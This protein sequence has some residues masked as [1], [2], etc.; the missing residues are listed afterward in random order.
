MTTTL[1]I[2][3]Y[4]IKV[5]GV[6]NSYNILLRLYSENIL[7]S[8]IIVYQV[9][10]T[11]G[12]SNELLIITIFTVA[13]SYVSHQLVITTNKRFC[14]YFGWDSKPD[15]KLFNVWC[16]SFKISYIIHSYYLHSPNMNIYI[17][18]WY[19]SMD[20][21]EKWTTYKKN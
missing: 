10:L 11:Y 19:P 6:A 16:M 20:H 1:T 4:T 15:T 21:T 8:Y 14:L 9:F 12:V 7:L 5:F 13:Y 2:K 17:G 18:S 3:I